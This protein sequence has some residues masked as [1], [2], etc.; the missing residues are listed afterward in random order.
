MLS[1]K[2]GDFTWDEEDE[3]KVDMVWQPADHEEDDHYEAHL[4]YL[5]LLLQRPR[6]GGL[7][8]RVIGHA[9]HM[10]PTAP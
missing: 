6:D 2:R 7:P 9:Q 5:P 8:G 10:V 1:T 3:Y 4:Y